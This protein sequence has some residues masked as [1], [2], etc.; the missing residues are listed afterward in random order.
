MR[1]FLTHMF[2]LL[3]FLPP[4]PTSIIEDEASTLRKEI[5]CESAVEAAYFDEL[6]VRMP[7]ELTKDVLAQARKDGARCFEAVDLFLEGAAVSFK[8]SDGQRVD[9]IEFRLTPFGK[10]VY[11]VRER[12]VPWN[13]PRA[14]Q[15]D[16]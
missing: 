2:A 1:E 10:A 9:V 13:V 16:V 15:V 11:R 5:F 6:S 3:L 8:R 14:K 12:S 7:R 4:T